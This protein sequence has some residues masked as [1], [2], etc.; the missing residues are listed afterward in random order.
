MGIPHFEDLD[1]SILLDA[2]E[3]RWTASEKMDGSY[4]EFGFDKQGE[5]YT[6]RKNGFPIHSIDEWSQ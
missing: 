3:L 2:L 6:R 5:F 4:M 1:L